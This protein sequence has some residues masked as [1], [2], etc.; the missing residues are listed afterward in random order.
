MNVRCSTIGKRLPVAPASQLDRPSAMSTRKSSSLLARI[1]SHVS[2][3]HA[4]VSP[5]RVFLHALRS[6]VSQLHSNSGLREVQRQLSGSG[7]SSSG[8]SGS[9]SSCSTAAR[10][11]AL[12]DRIDSSRADVRWQRLLAPSSCWHGWRGLST[13]PSRTTDEPRVRRAAGS[14]QCTGRRL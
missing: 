3:I 12:C 6:G 4:A 2:R 14:W 11:S 8:G 7:G 13:G 5:G 1:A 10:G 9:G